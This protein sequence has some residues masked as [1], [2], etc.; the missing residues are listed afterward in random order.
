MVKKTVIEVIKYCGTV[1]VVSEERE[2]EAL[3]ELY[4]I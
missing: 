1:K 2:K 3:K 4:Q